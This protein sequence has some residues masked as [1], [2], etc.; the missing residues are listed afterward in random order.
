[1]VTGR[2]LLT[3]EEAAPDPAVTLADA[4]G[5]TESLHAPPN[6]AV[7]PTPKGGFTVTHPDLGLAVGSLGS[8]VVDAPSVQVIGGLPMATG[9]FEFN[10]SGTPSYSMLN[11]PGSQG[12]SELHL[13]GGPMLSV[14]R[15]GTSELS[16]TTTAFGTPTSVEA[17][18]GAEFAKV[19]ILPTD[20]ITHSDQSV[21]VMTDFTASLTCRAVPGGSAV[22]MGTWSA[23]LWYWAAANDDDDE[24]DDD[25]SDDDDEG[26]YVPVP[27]SGSTG[28]TAIDPLA[29]IKASNPLVYD[30][31][32]SEED[33]YLFDGG[34]VTG[35]LEDWSSLPAIPFATPPGGRDSRVDLGGAIQIVTAPVNPGVPASKVT[36][37]IGAMS[38]Q[39]VD[40]RGL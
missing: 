25:E 35:Y 3:R 37:S 34:G 6:S 9:G 27:L 8:S 32:D 15:V 7:T 17:T 23:T 29:A 26:E 11:D 21:V 36:A 38:C 39:A 18:A 14:Q 24:G 1:V 13:A 5:A 40:K 16:G 10:N 31:D 12:A 4:F 28:S 20:F 19:R 22:A 33:V 30:D 2:L